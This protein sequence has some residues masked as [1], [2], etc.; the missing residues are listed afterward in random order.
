M[1]FEYGHRPR[2]WSLCAGFLHASSMCQLS[3]E[4]RLCSFPCALPFQ[5]GVSDF[6]FKLYEAVLSSRTS[7]DDRNVL[8]PML[9][10]R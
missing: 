8:I 6:F 1:A 7:H 4:L 3:L 10:I 5:L 2:L 9:S